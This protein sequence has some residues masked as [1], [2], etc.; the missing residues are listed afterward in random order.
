M[1]TRWEYSTFDLTCRGEYDKGKLL[2]TAVNDIDQKPRRP[3]DEFLNQLALQGWELV[4]VQS[5]YTL[6]KG[7]YIFKRLL[8][9]AQSN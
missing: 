6:E 5:G 3:F 8:T 1:M 9:E 2:L 7:R 4:A